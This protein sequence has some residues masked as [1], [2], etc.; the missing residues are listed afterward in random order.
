MERRRVLVVCLVS[1]LALGIG[2]T[3]TAAADAA[4]SNATA[5]Q[6][7]GSLELDKRLRL[8]PDRPG[9]IRVTA[10]FETPA[11]LFELET[12]LPGRATVVGT[13]GFEAS[14]GRYAWD[15]IT[16]DPSVTYRLSVNETRE[17]RGPLTVRGE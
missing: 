2:A 8:T 15:G 16:D 5:A 17:R 14:G 13:D 10:Q 9:E 11:N 7:D 12:E 1:I 3:G 4:V 6:S